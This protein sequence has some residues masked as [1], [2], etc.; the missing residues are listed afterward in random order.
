MI[1]PKP[2]PGEN[3]PIGDLPPPNAPLKRFWA[4]LSIE[5]KS[6]RSS[7]WGPPGLCPQ[8]LPPC[9]SLPRGPREPQGPGPLESLS[10]VMTLSL[11]C[12]LKKSI[13]PGNT[14]ASLPTI[15]KDFRKKHYVLFD[16]RAGYTGIVEDHRPENGVRRRD[17]Q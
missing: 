11:L 17:R 3:P 6:G 10:G 1:T 8:G 13:K 15:C 16:E 5:S 9:G 14:S 12:Y 2:M 7:F 4:A